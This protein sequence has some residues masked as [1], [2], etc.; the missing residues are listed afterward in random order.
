MVKS[1]LSGLVHGND[2]GS[3]QKYL[4]DVNADSATPYISPS[5]APTT[6][7]VQT[8]DTFRKNQLFGLPSLRTLIESEQNALREAENNATPRT[9]YSL[10][11]V[12]VDAFPYSKCA[13]YLKLGVVY[14]N[15]DAK[16]SRTNQYSDGARHSRTGKH[17]SGL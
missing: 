7:E 8:S 11:Q 2:D 10:E 13:M 6:F 14:V 5:D 17:S 16:A 1:K 12:D 3:L 9:K 15:E 4:L